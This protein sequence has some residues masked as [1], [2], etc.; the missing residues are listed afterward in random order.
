MTGRAASGP[1]TSSSGARPGPGR[2]ALD[3]IDERL[4]IKGLEY[5]V[6]EH[7]NNLAWS[8]T[9]GRF[10]RAL[11]FWA[12]QAMYV[13][14]AL[15]LLR[16]LFTGSYKRP[17]EA[18]WLVGVSM[19]ALV[20]GAIF[21]GTVLKWDQEGVEALEHNLEVARLLGG[22]GFWF[23]DE[24]S[25]H[26]PLLVRLYVAHVAIVPGLILGLLALHFLLVKRHGISPLPGAP[27]GSADSSEPS[28]RFT[29][30]LR[31]LGACG[32]VLLGAT[33]A[34]AVLWPPRVGS[35][36][37]EGIEV[38][39]PPWMFY[40]LYS[41]E[42]WFGLKGILWGAITLFGV[43]ALVPFVD[44]RP[45]RRWRRRRVALALA[46]IALLAM[47]VLTII[48]AVTSPEQHIE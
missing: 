36:A 15:H 32:L 43:L 11:H 26:N 17:R 10:A 9:G 37:V 3:A 27:E 33:G 20:I 42:N 21:T 41:L 14:A 5:P 22:V 45:E 29:R 28:E 18:N 6:P 31:R 39:K 1:A 2:R 12:A 34:L 7:A 23:T 30:H 46:G 19:F 24:F 16:V 13:L 35:T 40:W 38:T 4:G 47:V 25:R 48:T 44:R 8:V